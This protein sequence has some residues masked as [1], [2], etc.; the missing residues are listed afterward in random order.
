MNQVNDGIGRLI[1]I[2]TFLSIGMF[3]VSLVF[4]GRFSSALEQQHLSTEGL[5]PFNPDPIGYPGKSPAILHLDL[6]NKNACT[7]F[8]IDSNYAITAGHCLAGQPKHNSVQNIGRTLEKAIPVKTVGYNMRVDY[9]LIQGD[10]SG[11]NQAKIEPTKSFS[12]LSTGYQFMAC[13]FPEGQTPVICTTL[14]SMGPS[15]F[16]IIARGDFYPGMSG[17]PVIEPVS[18]LVIG[19]VQAVAGTPDKPD[20][21]LVS[22]LTGFLH[23]MGIEPQ[24]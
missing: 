19:L 9:G 12:Q 23:A 21:V 11:F 7:A 6:S 13:G 16:L 15:D 20:L 17:G 24:L 5:M 4:L 10:F 8:V 14:L 1:G 18:G 22:P 3:I 2:A